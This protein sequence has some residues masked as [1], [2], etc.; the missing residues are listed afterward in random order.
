[1]CERHAEGFAYHLRGGRGAEELAAA[2][3]RSAG[4]AHGF[5]GVGQR[6]HSVGEARAYGLHLAGVLAFFGEERH[7]AGNQHA[8]QIAR[9]GEGHHHGGQPFVARGDA[10]HAAARGEGADEAPEDAGGV[11]TVGQGIEHAG[12]ALR[13]AVARVGAIGREGHG[14][15]ALELF[16]GGV[17]EQGD[18]P[19]AGV[20]AEGDGRAIGGANAAVGAEDEKFL[21]AEEGGVPAHAGV[22][23]PA[24][25]VARGTVQQHFRRY[26]SG[27]LRAARFGGHIE[28]GGV[29]GI[30]DTFGSYGH[31]V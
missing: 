8:R 4:A 28:D 27:A 15:E 9:A 6:D 3:G 18:F 16:R 10:E 29:A 13:A 12:G 17:H 25:E 11:V 21:A 30:E 19:V 7:A 5:G 23:G 26:G 31:A 2:S 14:A 1:M 24:E 20:I 22:L